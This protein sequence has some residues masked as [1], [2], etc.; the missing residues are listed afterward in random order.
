MSEKRKLLI[1]Y[2]ALRKVGI[3]KKY[4]SPNSKIGVDF[5]FDEFDWLLFIYELENILGQ[6]LL[7]ERIK[8]SVYISDIVLRMQTIN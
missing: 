6:E 8:T 1:I 7:I 2:C 3:E 4:F 5:Y